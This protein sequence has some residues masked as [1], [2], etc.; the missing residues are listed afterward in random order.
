VVLGAPGSGKST[1]VRHL[2]LCLAGAHID[3]WTRPAALPQLGAWPHGKLTPVYVELRR[4]VASTHFPANTNEQPTAD[5]LWEYLKAD[6]LRDDFAAYADDLKY[7]LENGHAVLI[8][9]GLDEV[10]YPEGEL[11]KRQKQLRSL[12]QSLNDRYKDSRIIVASRPHAYEGWILPGFEAITIAAFEDQ[13]RIELATRLYRTAGLGEQDATERANAL[14][15]ALEPVDDELKDRP[16]FVTL[17]AII[18]LENEGSVPTRGGALYRQSIL[19]LLDKWTQSKLGMKALPDILGTRTVAELSDR[20][21]ALAYDVQAQHGEKPGT[22]EIPEEWLYKHL[23]PMG[24]TVAAELIPY[25][26]ENAGVLVSPGQNA[27]RDVFRFA[28]R[29]FQEYLA[30]VQVLATCD[31]AKAFAQVRTLIQSKPQTWREPM[32]LLGD[33]LI[34]ADRVGELWDVI[35]SLLDDADPPEQIAADDARWWGVWLAARLVEEHQP[36]ESRTGRGERAI[37]DSLIDWLVKL[38]ETPRALRPVERAACGRALGLLG[39]PRPGVLELDFGD[40][41]WCDVPAGTH[42]LGSDEDIDNPKH[43]A[44]LNG[45]KIGKYPITYRQFQAFLDDIAILGEDELL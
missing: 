36:H 3:G 38:V 34:D 37:R 40:D 16:L 35:D 39:D 22:P 19:L 2:V 11:P 13:H 44:T 43:T 7:D 28:H 4:F 33:A 23:K 12:A 8:L 9:D 42:S 21:A 27:E 1:F 30:A 14:N 31:A 45:F 24:R 26:C 32:L 6:V 5:H 10:P 15:A 29:S 41:Y 20:L 25:L 17:M 18:F